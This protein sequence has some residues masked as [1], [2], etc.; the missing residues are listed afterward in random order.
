MAEASEMGSFAPEFSEPKK[1]LL[2]HLKVLHE[3][4]LEDLAKRMKISRMA[5]HKHLVALESR[6]LV[7][8]EKQ[9]KGVGR[10]RLIYRLTNRS[11]N[12]FPKTYGAMAMCALQFIDRNMGRKG[13]EKVLRERQSD[14]FNQYYERLRT[15]SL[16]ERVEELAKIRDH[17]GY[18]AESK[19]L[20]SGKF[21]IME[22]N[23]PVIQVAQE[24]WEA[25]STERELFEKLL[26]ASVETTHRAAKGDLTC[27]FLIDP[28]SKHGHFTP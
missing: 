3:A 6:G 18:M 2:W 20:P 25:C 1:N 11:G 4:G 24:Y 15:K 7:E 9:R 14:L 12:V 28:K 17:E 22:Y 10:P 26:D 13:V 27:R 23:C 21:V 19:K 5:V 16:E 8:S